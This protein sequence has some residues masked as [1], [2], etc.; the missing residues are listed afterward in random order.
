MLLIAIRNGFFFLD[1]R[2][3]GLRGAIDRETEGGGRDQRGDGTGEAGMAL[4][5]EKRD[6][7]RHGGRGIDCQG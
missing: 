7:R 6:C 5:G 3:L 1:A 2:Q 4:G